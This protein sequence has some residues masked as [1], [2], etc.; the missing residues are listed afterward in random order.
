MPPRDGGADPQRGC[1]PC[2][3]GSLRRWGGG[4]RPEGALDLTCRRRGFGTSWQQKEPESSRQPPATGGKG[5]P[6]GGRGT[7]RNSPGDQRRMPRNGDQKCPQVPWDRSPLL[8][9]L[10]SCPLQPAPRNSQEPGPLEVPSQPREGQAG[11]AT[12]TII[13]PSELQ[14]PL[15]QL[16][17]LGSQ[18]RGMSG[19]SHVEHPGLQPLTFLDAKAPSPETGSFQRSQG[20]FFLGAL[21]DPGWESGGPGL[22]PSTHVEACLVLLC[23]QVHLALWEA[24]DRRPSPEPGPLAHPS[25]APQQPV[26][27]PQAPGVLGWGLPAGSPSPSPSPSGRLPLAPVFL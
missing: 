13:I 14:L 6:L 7:S 1:H 19:T 2:L 10:N 12:A 25:A 3:P 5:V 17:S 16:N 24:L 26:Q 21:R 23:G 11:Q 4:Q 27:A 18:E 22:P 8:R 20:I 15:N 9:G